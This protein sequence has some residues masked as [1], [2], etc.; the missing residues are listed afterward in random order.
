MRIV[1][2][3][4]RKMTDKEETYAYIAKKLRFPDHFGKNLDALYDCLTDIRKK[5]FIILR[6]TDSLSS[7]GDFGDA[8]LEVFRDAEK[9][10]KKLSVITSK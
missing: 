8:L 2:L 7:S 4:C 5:T 9:N 10:V 1:T 6:H 3:D